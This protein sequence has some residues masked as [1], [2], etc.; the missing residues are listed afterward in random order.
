MEKFNILIT[1]VSK[2]IQLINLFREA[3]YNT[4]PYGEIVG[5][6]I[7]NNALGLKFCDKSYIVKNINDENYL[8]NIIDICLCN[9]IKLII[10]TRDQELLFYSKNKFIF[11]NIGIFVHVSD[12][13]TINICNNKIKFIDFCQKNNFP[14]PI[15]YNNLCQIKKFPVFIK[16]I[17]GQAS[18]NINVIYKYEDL[19]KIPN[20]FDNY[21]VQELIIADEYTIDYLGDLNGNFIDC[22]VRKRIQIVNGESQITETIELSEIEELCKNIGNKLNLIGHCN[23]QCFFDEKN[24]DIKLIEINPRFGGASHLGIRA[25]LDSPKNIVKMCL[26]KNINIKELNKN[27]KM[28]RHTTDVFINEKFTQKIFCIDID[29]TLCTEGEDY[30]LSKPIQKVIDKINYLYENDNYIKLYTARGSKSKTDW[31]I[32][33]EEQLLKWGVKYNELIMGKPFAD[34]YIDNKAINVLDWI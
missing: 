14:V 4:F 30:S 33:T 23:I 21:I 31:K 17:I 29:G 5:I 8:T 19:E 6:D 22:V 25:G 10:P 15:T 24:K 12:Y 2:K 32:F 28:Y 9:N 34:H 7:D 13:E 18:Q 1:S 26:G 27:L 20:L 3:I 11:Q 16:P